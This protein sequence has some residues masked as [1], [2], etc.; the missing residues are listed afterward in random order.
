M[1]TMIRT[2][3]LAAVLLFV[4]ACSMEQIDREWHG[5]VE[6][7]SQCEV[8][9]DCVQVY[10]GCPLGCSAGVSVE[11]EDEANRLADD[12]IARW[13]MGIQDCAYDCVATELDCVEE[14]CEVVQADEF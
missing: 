5:W 13:S 3:F 12:L 7:H 10:P 14:R 8:V 6:G 4:S 2:T 1:Q 9:Q 11:H